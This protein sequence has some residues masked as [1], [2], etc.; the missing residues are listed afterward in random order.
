M[1]SIQLFGEQVI[2]KFADTNVPESKLS[3][4][5]APVALGG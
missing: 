4:A 3:D 2:P 5:K 1:E